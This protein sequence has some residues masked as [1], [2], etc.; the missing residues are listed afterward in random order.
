MLSARNYH[1]KFL[2]F[3]R[4]LLYSLVAAGTLLFKTQ[5]VHHVRISETMA[6]SILLTKIHYLQASNLAQ[7]TSQVTIVTIATMLAQRQ[8]AFAGTRVAHKVGGN[9]CKLTNVC[10]SQG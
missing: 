1:C 3:G 7:H 9:K 10:K 8:T 6:D 2:E 5:Y 4:L